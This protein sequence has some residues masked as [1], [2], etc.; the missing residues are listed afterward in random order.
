MLKV[1]WIPEEIFQGQLYGP[2]WHCAISLVSVQYC[3]HSCQSL[4]CLWALCSLYIF[5]ISMNFRLF[6]S[7]KPGLL[8]SP[9]ANNSCCSSDFHMS[10]TWNISINSGLIQQTGTQMSTFSWLVVESWISS[11]LVS[12]PLIRYASYTL[13]CHITLSGCAAWKFGF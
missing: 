7:F 4:N 8:M 1:I 5:E 2:V 11:S 6:C 9:P 3:T 10:M 13:H 12:L